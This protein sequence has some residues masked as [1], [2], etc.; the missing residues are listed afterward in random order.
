LALLLDPVG[1][2]APFWWVAGQAL[3]L[4]LA[5]AHGV[6]AMPGAVALMPA[7]SAG[8]FLLVVA[9]LLWL[10]LWRRRW[11]WWGAAPLALGAALASTA[12]A[13]DLLVT[14]DGKHLAVRTPDGGLAL[15]RPRAGDYVRDLLAE[16]AGVEA[17]FVEI[18]RAQGGACSDALCI[19]ELASGDRRWRVL[20]TRSRDL[21][22]WDEMIAACA[23]ADIVVSDRTLPAACRPRWLKADRAMLRESGGLAFA[24]RGSPAVTSVRDVVGR[25]PWAR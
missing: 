9:G 5:L 17:E 21:V 1:L 20:A 14:G 15:L 10:G 16:L 24:L 7:V 13:P 19:Y 25:H 18:E 8:A 23:S 4:L 2:G 12:S 6:A 3:N 11:R 22:R